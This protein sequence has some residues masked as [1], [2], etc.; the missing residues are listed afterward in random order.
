MKTTSNLSKTFAVPL[1]LLGVPFFGWLLNKFGPVIWWWTND[2]LIDRMAQESAA[3][4]VPYIRWAVPLFAWFVTLC[5]MVPIPLVVLTLFALFIGI[6]GSPDHPSEP[7]TVDSEA[8]E[9]LAAP[10]AP[11]RSRKLRGKR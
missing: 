1:F 7:S 8:A 4:I 9:P 6:V 5:V 3:W 11:V 10:P 2:F